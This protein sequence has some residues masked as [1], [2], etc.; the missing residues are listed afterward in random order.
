MMWTGICGVYPVFATV[1][2]ECWGEYWVRQKEEDEE[3]GEKDGWF[4]LHFCVCAPS[5][6]CFANHFFWAQTAPLYN[7]IINCNGDDIC[8]SIATVAPSSL[9]FS[10]AQS[11]TLYVRCGKRTGGRGEKLVVLYAT[12]PVVVWRC[13]RENLWLPIK[14]SNKQVPREILLRS[15]ISEV[16]A[17]V[18]TKL[19]FWCYSKY[20]KFK[21]SHSFC[22]SL[23][24]STTSVQQAGGSISGPFCRWECAQMELVA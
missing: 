14:A 8:L 9:L 17:K 15:A 2:V 4:V 24:F 19:K 21:M 10:L 12:F 23:L 20:S 18:F 22:T 16:K 7:A 1:V 13:P 3:E 6:H 11:T 5:R